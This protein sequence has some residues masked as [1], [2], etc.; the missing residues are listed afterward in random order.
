M[1]KWLN[2]TI[3]IPLWHL[4]WGPL[5]MTLGSKSAFFW[6]DLLTHSSS[7]LLSKHISFHTHTPDQ[8]FAGHRHTVRK[9]EVLTVCASAHILPEIEMCMNQWRRSSFCFNTHFHWL[10]AAHMDQNRH[11][12]LITWSFFSV[13][14]H[15]AVIKSYLIWSVLVCLRWTVAFYG[16]TWSFLRSSSFSRFMRWAD[17]GECTTP[18]W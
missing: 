6:G 13:M 15:T 11:L 2:K 10:S 16:A 8:R 18:E 4:V 5:N 9:W 17:G 1:L 12:N 7:Y 14:F 3:H